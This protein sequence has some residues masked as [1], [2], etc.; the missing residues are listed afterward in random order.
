MMAE[1]A[2]QSACTDEW[3]QKCPAATVPIATKQRST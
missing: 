2:A 1:A 3:T